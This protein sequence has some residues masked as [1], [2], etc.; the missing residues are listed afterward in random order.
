MYGYVV[1]IEYME[2]ARVHS[3]VK[4]PVGAAKF[5]YSEFRMLK[6]G[7]PRSAA[8]IAF[9]RCACASILSFGVAHVSATSVLH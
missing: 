1:C 7:V 5:E 2:G 9:L 6:I 3:F 8:C 4:G